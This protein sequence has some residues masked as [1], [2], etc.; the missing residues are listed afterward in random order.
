M[1]NIQQQKISIWVNQQNGFFATAEL[2]VFKTVKHVFEN[3]DRTGLFLY[4]S[5]ANEPELRFGVFKSRI[6]TSTQDIFLALF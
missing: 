6:P 1:Q 5:I 2:F 4:W 3:S